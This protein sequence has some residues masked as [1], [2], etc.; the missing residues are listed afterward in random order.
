MNT[1]FLR[2]NGGWVAQIWVW[3]DTRLAL[4]ARGFE[5]FRP[6]FGC[7]LDLIL[8]F[9]VDSIR[10]SWVRLENFNVFSFG[11]AAVCG[12]SEARMMVTR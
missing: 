12:C 4:F 3:T 5:L 11:V 9:V 10:S 8:K 1:G 2:M 6:V 7:F